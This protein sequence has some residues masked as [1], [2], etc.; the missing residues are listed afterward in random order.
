MHFQSSLFRFADS[1]LSVIG[2]TIII[3]AAIATSCPPSFSQTATALENQKFR[4][5][6][7]SGISIPVN[8][9]KE[10]DLVT[11]VDGSATNGYFVDL[12]ACYLLNDWV[13]LKFDG[14][15]MKHPYAEEE[16]QSFFPSK[17]DFS[18]SD[19]NSLYY[20]GGISLRIP[21]KYFLQLDIAA[22]GLSLAGGDLQMF[23][24]GANGSRIQSNWDYPQNTSFVIKADI[25]G[26][27]ELILN[28]LY[29]GLQAGYLHSNN[30]VTGTYVEKVVSSQDVILTDINDRYIPIRTINIG[31]L[32]GFQF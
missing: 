9:Y 3:V 25:S 6:I 17:D 1:R 26:K 8:A 16:I 24:D 5:E 13:A 20:A 21:V 28:K 12:N 32:F 4:I 18:A 15:Y 14:G 29:I 10:I 7:S 23:R 19:Y 30:N 27:Y 11:N 31:I 2:N 22:G